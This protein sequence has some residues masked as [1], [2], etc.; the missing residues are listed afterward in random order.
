MPSSVFSIAKRGRRQL[1]RGKSAYTVAPPLFILTCMRSYSSLVCGMLGQHPQL[2]G[3]L[4]VNLLAG[5]TVGGVVKLFRRIRPTSL[6]G[7]LR[8]IAQ[9]EYGA[10]TE[11]TVNAAWDWLH[12]RMNWST[13]RMF[14]HI[15]AAVAPR[16]LIE[17][18]PLNVMRPVF[19]QRMY[20]YFPQAY[21]LHLTRHPRPTCRSIQ[22]MVEE[23]DAK[24]GTRRAEELDPEGLW[25]RAHENIL[26]F[27]RQLPPGQM[28]RI[29]GEDLL[30]DIDGYLPQIEAW[31]GIDSTPTT[32]E[33][34]KHPECS[35]YACMGPSNAPFGSDPNYLKQPHYQP[36][37]I[38][39]A[40]LDGLL[41][42]RTPRQE[43]FSEATRRIAQQLG[44][45]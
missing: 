19:L 5:D 4:E 25:R 31:L 29:R 24:K 2:Y 27:E 26:D 20:R 28:M 21:Y 32:L 30:S 8:T 23:T 17:K 15:A 1:I 35:P 16:R 7:L 10:Q 18:S 45:R 9:L 34:M 41:E 36:R 22:Q 3:L 11:D 43:V 33:A 42:F 38:A 37:P 6:N 40:R 14:E 13:R 12:P 39:E 44:Y